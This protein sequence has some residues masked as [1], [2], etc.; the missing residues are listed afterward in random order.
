MFHLFELSLIRPPQFS[1]SD[2]L[3]RAQYFIIFYIS[4]SRFCFCHFLMLHQ[5]KKVN[6]LRLKIVQCED[7][8]LIYDQFKSRQIKMNVNSIRE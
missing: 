4:S 6:I 7:G 1:E 2:P 8:G 5:H 3:V